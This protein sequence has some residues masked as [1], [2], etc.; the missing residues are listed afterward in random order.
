[1][2]KLFKPLTVTT[3]P[4]FSLACCMDTLMDSHE[5]L[6]LLLLLEIVLSAGAAEKGIAIK[7]KKYIIYMT[8]L[9]IG[10]I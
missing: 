6:L 3:L 5:G 4:V 8:I 10:S 9:D 7:M 2:P 1:M